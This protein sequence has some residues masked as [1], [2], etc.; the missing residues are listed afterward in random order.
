MIAGEVEEL[1]GKSVQEY[2]DYW[3][4]RIKNLLNED[5]FVEVSTCDMDCYGWSCRSHCAMRFA[6]Q[7][8]Y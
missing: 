8:F 7:A 5:D 1:K 3:I 4:E 6:S 2:V